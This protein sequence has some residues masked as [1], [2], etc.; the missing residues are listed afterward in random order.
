MTF[1]HGFV[2]KADAVQDDVLGECKEVFGHDVVATV[3]QGA[4]T[5]RFDQ[6][7]ASARAAT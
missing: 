4:S 6:R 7:D 5:L 3:D 1:G 2:T